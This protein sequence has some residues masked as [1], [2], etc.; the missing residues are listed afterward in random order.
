[1][2]RNI[3]CISSLPFKILK[4]LKSKKHQESNKNAQSHIGS[5]EKSEI[6]LQRIL[7]AKKM[8]WF[9]LI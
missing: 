5:Y 2:A 6:A 9:N 7:E 4:V 8:A 3:S 1:M